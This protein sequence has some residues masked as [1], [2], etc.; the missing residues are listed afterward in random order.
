MITFKLT[1]KSKKSSARVGILETPHGSIETPS[2]VNVATQATVKTLTSQDLKLCG[3]QILI[4]N[5]YHLH[6]RPGEDAMKKHGGIHNFMKWDGPV[7]TDS[8]GFQV[9]S[10][11]FGKDYGTGK[12]LKQ[13]SYEKI[14]QGAQPKLVKITEAGV[15]FRSYVDGK[16]LFL[17]PKES[18]H[19]Q[20]KIGADIIFAFDECT[21]PLADY[22]YNK[23]A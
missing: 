2:F 15:E 9:F 18:I 21:S 3:S 13:K 14:K 12:I 10:L 4:A 23:D 5:T 8:G 11:G 22:D 7:M 1:K 20:E 6:I 16:K 19:I 17:G